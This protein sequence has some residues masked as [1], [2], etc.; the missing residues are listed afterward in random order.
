[1]RDFDPFRPGS[2]SA[3]GPL[4]D[5]LHR[6]IRL[7]TRLA[8]KAGKSCSSGVPVCEAFCLRRSIYRTRPQSDP[9]R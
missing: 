8:T 9:F 4:A 5:F 3:W 7:F 1:M 6:R 2:M